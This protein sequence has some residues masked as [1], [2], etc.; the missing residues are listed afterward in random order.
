[1]VDGRIQCLKITRPGSPY[2]WKFVGVY[3]HVARSENQNA[4]S[5]LRSTLNELVS[6]ALVENHRVAVLGDFNAA[7]PGGRWGYSKWSS[8]GKED[9][10]M[11]EWVQA[12]GLTEVLH[13]ANRPQRGGRAKARRKQCLIGCLL[14]QMPAPYQ[15]SWY[16]GIVH[17]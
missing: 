13:M 5:L 16:S 11:N 1:M 10:V 12:S 3:Q 15:S 7:P 6:A 17:I 4:T 2:T 9:L 8:T 14:L